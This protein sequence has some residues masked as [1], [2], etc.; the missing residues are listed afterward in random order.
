MSGNYKTLEREVRADV[1]DKCTVG[2]QGG[3]WGRG[4]TVGLVGNKKLKLEEGK[5]LRTEG[6]LSTKIYTQSKNETDRCRR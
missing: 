3:Y 4:G 6:G 1:A 2:K 5:F